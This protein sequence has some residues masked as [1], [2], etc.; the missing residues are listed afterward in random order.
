MFDGTD[1]GRQIEQRGADRAF[2]EYAE[3]LTLLLRRGHIDCL[4]HLDLIKIHCLFPKSY[5]AVATL[6]PLLELI[7]KN[8]LAIEINTAGWRKKV[9]EQYPTMAIVK[10]AVDLGIS[11]T[12]SSDAHSYAQVAE[13]YERLEALLQAEGITKISRFSRHREK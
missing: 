8:G 9:G 1:Q 6:E 7:R 13:G 3:Q 4:S 11:I 5:D 2:S 12:I 10:R